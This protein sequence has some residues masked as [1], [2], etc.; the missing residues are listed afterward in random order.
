MF[1]KI[2][3][4]CNKCSAKFELRGNHI[5]KSL[6]LKCPNCNQQFPH[7]YFEELKTAMINLNNLT[8]KTIGDD[9][10]EDSFFKNSGFN[11]S[12]ENEL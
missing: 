6:D 7:T 4:T 9:K 12:V 5:E 10:N 1:F 8:E 2:V 11:L 3:I